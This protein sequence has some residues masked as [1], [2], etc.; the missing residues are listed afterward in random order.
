M[1]REERYKLILHFDPRAEALY[2]LR[3][4]P[5]EQSPLPTEAAKP[6]RRRLLEIARDHLQRSAA[7]RNFESRL[8]SWLRELQLE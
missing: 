5:Q 2:D 3:T 7:Q 4:D 8:R 1:I 6:V